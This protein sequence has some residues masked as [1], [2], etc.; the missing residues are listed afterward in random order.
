MEVTCSRPRANDWPSS[1]P[2]LCPLPQNYT[3]PLLS[4]PLLLCYLTTAEGNEEEILGDPAHQEDPG[5][6]WPC[7]AAFLPA[8]QPRQLLGTHPNGRAF[9]HE[10]QQLGLGRPRVP[11]HQQVDVSSASE[12]IREPKGEPERQESPEAWAQ[13]IAVAAGSQ[14]PDPS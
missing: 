3:H 4:S 6:Q 11:Q 12:P 13:L 14:P 5:T 2:A 10:L 9:L 1:H 7:P 8:G